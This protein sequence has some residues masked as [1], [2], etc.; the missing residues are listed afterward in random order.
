MLGPYLKR[1]GI[2]IIRPLLN[3]RTNQRSL[4]S[5]DIR[6]DFISNYYEFIYNTGNY[7]ASYNMSSLPCFF[8]SMISLFSNYY[9]Y[10]LTQK[11]MHISSQSTVVK[12]GYKTTP[13]YFNYDLCC[14]LVHFRTQSKPCLHLPYFHP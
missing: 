7:R 12:Y 1:R 8:S 5:C 14:R 6:Y 10:K 3:I 2:L 11:K 13:I 4:L 9:G